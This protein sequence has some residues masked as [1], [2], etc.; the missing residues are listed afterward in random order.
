M[1]QPIATLLAEPF[2]PEQLRHHEGKGLT[3]V[4]ISEVIARLN[5]VLGVGNWS[6][7]VKRTWEAGEQPTDTGVYPAWVMA[8]VTLTANIRSASL[9]EDE[10]AYS[11][12]ARVDGVG[13]QQVK[14]LRNGSGV[15]DL[16]DEYKGAV[17]DALKKAAQH[18]GVGLELAR[19]D[20]A[21]AYEAAQAPPLDWP[22]VTAYNGTRED[23]R[24]RARALPPA[25]AD[26]LRTWW[27][28]EGLA[29]PL[30]V[31]QAGAYSEKIAGYEVQ[32]AA[33]G[34]DDEGTGAP[35]PQ[36]AQVTPPADAPAA[37]GETLVSDLTEVL[38]RFDR[39]Q[40]KAVREW[41][42]KQGLPIG[43]DGKPVLSA[44]PADRLEALYAQVAAA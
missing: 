35:H 13:G 40:L 4:P 34:A 16:G 17:S 19:K 21:M 33:G 36:A 43:P 29:W 8:H 1:T 39:D 25:L 6:Y 27:K 26:A 10:F 37:G 18:L 30:T 14:L 2:A 38:A 22:T 3:Y 5:R 31:D 44:M 11:P 20:E 7:E 15:V 32:V 28:T 41:A 23:L 42:A 24:D 12:V 9:A